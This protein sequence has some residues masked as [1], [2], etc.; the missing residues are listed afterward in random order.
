MD[1]MQQSLNL[2]KDKNGII[3]D[4]TTASLTNKLSKTNVFVLTDEAEKSLLELGFYSPSSELNAADRIAGCKFFGTIPTTKDTMSYHL[5]ISSH[6]SFVGATT[7]RLW[8]KLISYYHQGFQSD[9][10]S[11]R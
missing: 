2:E 1:T 10:F 6:L 5:E 3:D 4:F 9:G 8:P 7:G 11:E